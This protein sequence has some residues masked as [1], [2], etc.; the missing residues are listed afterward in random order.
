LPLADL[1]IVASAPYAGCKLSVDV[2]DGERQTDTDGQTERQTEYRQTDGY[3]YHLKLP[4]HF[5]VC[6]A[7]P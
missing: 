7:W 6:V 5:S 3:R 4:S 1:E 2:G